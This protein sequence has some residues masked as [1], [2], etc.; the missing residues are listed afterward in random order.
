MN[1]FA[2]IH[3]WFGPL[4]R[5]PRFSVTVVLILAL[6][7][8]INVATLGLLYRYYVSPLP[9]SSGGRIA[10][11][12]FAANIPAGKSMS[13]PTY[14]LL[15]KKAPSL[16]DAGLY[17]GTGYNLVRGNETRRLQ[18]AEMTASAFSTLGVQPLLG[19]V[20]EPQSDK[21]GAKPVAVLSYRLWQSLFGGKR[22]ALGA[23]LR[24]DDKLYTVIGVMPKGF[25]F[26]TTQAGLWTPRV[27]QPYELKSNQMTSF[28][29]KM[30]VR[31]APGSSLHQLTSQANAV[32]KDEAGPTGQSMLAQY[33]L[34][35]VAQGWRASR[36]GGLTRSLTLVQVATALLMLLV[37]FN[38]ANLFLA[39]TFAR[40]SELTLR[41][42]LGAGTGTL[43]ASM[44]RENFIL[45]LF[46][47]LVGVFFG[48][49]LL[50]LFSG[51]G[52]GEA[53][54]SIPGTSWPVL[55]VI[56]IALA[57]V[58]T[59]IF[60][61]VGL[62]FLHGRN[63][64][65]AL[66]EDGTRTSHGP[67]ARRVRR[68]LLVSQ[69]A[70]AC[71]L[72]GCGLL[73]G[74]SLLNLNTVNLGF[75]ADHTVTFKF[76]VPRSQYSLDQMSAGLQ[77]LR[78]SVGRLAGIESASIA[79]EVPFDGSKIGNGVFPRP[80]NS[81]VHPSAFTTITDA[82]F[83]HALGLSLLAGRNFA[84]TDTK[85]KMGIAII[86]TL[87][88]KQLFN[89][90]HAVGRQFSFYGEH[91]DGP[92]ILFRVIGV[93][94]TSHRVSVGAAPAQGNVYVDRDQVLPL[95]P[96]WWSHRT[97]YLVV[98]SPLS[99]PTIVSEVSKTA[100]QILPG[101]PLYNVKTMQQRVSG[102]LA[103]NRLLTILV[104][105]FAF[106][107]LL[108]AGIGL[109]AVQA[110]AVAQRAREFAI[111][112]ALGAERSQLL[113]MVIGE[114]ARLLVIGLVIG[115]IG[116]ALIGI[117]FASAFY[118]IAAVDPLSMIVVAAVLAVATLAASW[119]PAWRASRTTP[120]E[121]LRG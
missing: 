28:M 15:R 23:T 70:L 59:A 72:V 61:A 45:S 25:A 11:V 85:S 8:G 98:R 105:L 21:S 88:A 78:R 121:A 86:D 117:T 20:F 35:L 57:L 39:R 1:S 90:E 55:I 100:G 6:G 24:L 80:V 118:G 113:A 52:V 42:I 7:I 47:A 36:I 51:N 12:Y 48:R 14:E 97:W 31:L 108:L 5:N 40:R 99:T 50:G 116:L 22:S 82:G 38:L 95:Q 34:H 84:P 107:A 94:S 41:R 111:R 114:A 71:A 54:S 62:G 73:L 93:V 115:L 91:A 19:R 109:Y 69:I 2:K 58:S 44:A 3:T 32:L 92:G 56:T 26:P 87:T 102:A 53:A 9:Y 60:T 110:Y 83:I 81:T 96:L 13:I 119:L 33:Q 101:I 63:L 10:T 16:A 67:V 74:R 75:K 66:G 49:F 29:D 79:S 18:G 89:T 46:G 68:T 43:A 112:I 104:G 4:F 65:S 37:W 76:D 77:S 27:I 106:G 103:S 64:A 30:V 120:S 17:R